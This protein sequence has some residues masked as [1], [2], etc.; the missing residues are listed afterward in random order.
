MEAV[1]SVPLLLMMAPESP[2][3]KKGLMKG[4]D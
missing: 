3:S 2:L 1:A 4:E